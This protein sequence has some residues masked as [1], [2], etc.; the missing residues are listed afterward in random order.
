MHIIGLQIIFGQNIRQSGNLLSIMLVG[1][2]EHRAQCHQY[3]G[4]HDNHDKRYHRH[5]HQRP[6][7]AKALD[8]CLAQTATMQ[9]LALEMP[10]REPTGGMHLQ[11]LYIVVDTSLWW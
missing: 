2:S 9:I 10:F 1:G 11:M 6:P 3:G 4:E 5:W 7:G 8:R